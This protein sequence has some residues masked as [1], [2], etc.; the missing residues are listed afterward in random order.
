M[1]IEIK[2]RTAQEIFEAAKM[3]DEITGTEHDAEETILT[4]VLIAKMK[5]LEVLSSKKRKQAKG[6]KK[7]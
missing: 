5:F 4:S 7:R 3:L 2:H 1:K 6:E